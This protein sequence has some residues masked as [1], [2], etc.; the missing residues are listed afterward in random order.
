MK[1]HL[2]L[3]TETLDF[4]LRYKIKWEEGSFSIKTQWSDSLPANGKKYRRSH[5]DQEPMKHCQPLC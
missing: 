3:I 1:E 5:F 4:L 2:K